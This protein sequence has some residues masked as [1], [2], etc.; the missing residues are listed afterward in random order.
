MA[1]LGADRS[2]AKGDYAASRW[3]KDVLQLCAHTGSGEKVF[4]STGISLSAG[5]GEAAAPQQAIQSPC[6]PYSISS[7]LQAGSCRVPA[8][9]SLSGFAFLSLG[10]MQVINRQQERSRSLVPQIADVKQ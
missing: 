3:L 8:F 1:L 10:V 4:S 7:R 9:V 2:P 5:P 6:A